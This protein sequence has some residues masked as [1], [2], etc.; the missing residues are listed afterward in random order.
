MPSQSKQEMPAFE[1]GPAVHSGTLGLRALQL[2]QLAS[3]PELTIEGGVLKITDAGIQIE[4]NEELAGVRTR[5]MQLNPNQAELLNAYCEQNVPKL[6]KKPKD[7]QGS[8]SWSNWLGEQ[9]SQQQLLSFLKWHASFIEAHQTDPDV[10]AE[11]EVQKELYKMR[12]HRDVVIEGQ[13]WLHPNAEAAIEKVEG[14]QVYIGDIFDTI[15]QERLGYHLSDTSKIII[16]PLSGLHIK[17]DKKGEAPALVNIRQTA[18]HEFTH[19]VLGRLP[20]RWHNEAY[21]THIETSL[22][23]GQ[24]QVVNP[25]KRVIQKDD[26]I[27]ERRLAAALLAAGDKEIPASLPT[28]AY[29]EGY[30]LSGG[31]MATYEAALED[32]WGRHITASASV[33]Q[34]VGGHIE[35]LASRRLRFKPADGG[36]ERALTPREKQ[37]H[38]IRQ[39]LTE[40]REQPRLIFDPYFSYQ[41]RR[42]RKSAIVNGRQT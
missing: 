34:L 12:L 17:P 3:E 22:E 38:A 4:K 42:D 35:E 19:A 14:L 29:S 32:A 33:L 10:Q 25:D 5:V 41:Q 8:D 7:K 36:P 9:A 6:L 37:I 1:P 30:N 2:A 16:A 39:T 21:T 15:M 26:Y 20:W 28:R 24:P 23:N 40:L 31:A 27:Y 13:D 18:P 11:I